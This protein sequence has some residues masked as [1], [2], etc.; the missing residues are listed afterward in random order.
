MEVLQLIA[1]GHNNA[2][3]AETLFIAEK[4]VETYINSIY[5]DLGVSG[6][7]GIHARV[8]AALVFLEES[9]EPRQRLRLLCFGQVAMPEGQSGDD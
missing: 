3:I 7:H 6:E 2:S 9:E 8:K 5:Q 1:Q 4:S